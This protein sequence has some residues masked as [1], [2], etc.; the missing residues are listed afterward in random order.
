VATLRSTLDALGTNYE[1]L[2][3][4]VP[5]AMRMAEFRA[6]LA[7]HV[8]AADGFSGA[9]ECDFARSA[10]QESDWMVPYASIGVSC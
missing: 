6:F 2:A 4:A 1:C 3:G 5:G 9:A 8:H 7:A 10:Y